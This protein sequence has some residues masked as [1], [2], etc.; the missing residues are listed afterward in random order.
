MSIHT[1]RLFQRLNKIKI[2]KLKDNGQGCKR[3][4]TDIS[5]E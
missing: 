3:S 5:S 1:Q 2:S 4:L